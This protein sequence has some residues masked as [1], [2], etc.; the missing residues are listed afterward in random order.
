MFPS[1]SRLVLAI[2]ASASLVLA[3]STWLS[4]ADTSTVKTNSVSRIPAG[5]VVNERAVQGDLRL[6]ILAKGRLGSGDVD[7]VPSIAKKYANMFNLVIMAKVEPNKVDGEVKY[8]LDRVEVGFSMDIG[9][10]QVV[11]T[12]DTAKELGGK[13]DIIASQ[14]LAANEK[15]LADVTQIVRYRTLSMFDAKAIML[16]GDEHKEMIM[17]HLIWLNSKTGQI[18]TAVWLLGQDGDAER[19]TM[20]DDVIQVL[21]PSFVEDRVIDVKANKFF[22]GVPTPDAFALVRLPQGTPIKVDDKLAELASNKQYDTRSLGQLVAD[23]NSA[24]NKVRTAQR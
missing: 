23:L 20:P 1:L 10:K 19:Y 16:R 6:V 4:G 21:P 11:V 18:G 24:L 14:I 13:L 12:P 17:R 5:T 3:G 8:E 22:L 2:F 9:G 7:D 15:A